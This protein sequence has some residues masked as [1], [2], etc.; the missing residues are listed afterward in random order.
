M[1]FPRHLVLLLLLF[2][3]VAFA[4]STGWLF[5]NTGGT[6]T[7]N[8]TT[9]TLTLTSTI[10]TIKGMGCCGVPI[11]ETGSDLGTITLTTGPL[12]SGSIFHHALFDG[13]TITLVVDTG[14]SSGNGT[15]I[16]FTLAGTMNPLL[17]WM[18]K[19]GAHLGGNGGGIIDGTTGVSIDD[20]AQLVVSNG[21]LNQYNIIGG[22]TVIPEPGTVVLVVTGLGF[23][24]CM[25]SRRR[26]V[27]RA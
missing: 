12:I 16:P 14:I 11:V 13:G 22:S 24:A 26:P 18:D 21:T 6:M 20:F 3:S 10:T 9:N 5:V 8:P 19:S 23:L 17:W 27:V 1:K 15:L 2:P 7:F 25:K 4:D